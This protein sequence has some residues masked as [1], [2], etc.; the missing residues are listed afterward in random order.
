MRNPS[1]KQLEAFM[2][3]IETGTV[4]GAAEVIP[5]SQPAASKL[6]R[7][8]EAETRL[9]LFRRDGGR[10]VPTTA[11]LRLYDEVERLIGGINQLDRIVE[12]IRREG[13]RQ[14]SIGVFPALSGP[15]VHRVLDRFKEKY[16]D[17][18]IKIDVRGSQYLAEAIRLRRFDLAIVHRRTGNVSSWETT[19]LES[20]PMAC[21]LPKGHKLSEKTKIRPQD[22]SGEPFIAFGESSM[23][24][25]RVDAA[26][27]REGVRPNIVI[28]A[29]TAQNINELVAA[30]HGVTVASP[31]FTYMYSGRFDMREFLPKTRFELE[32]IRPIGSY[33]KAMSDAFVHAIRDELQAW[34][35]AHL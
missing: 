4:S 16:P 20:Q 5:I 26:F 35:K 17:T 30:G 31:L 21:I 28:E 34:T 8:L 3:V 9:E 6:I 12:T 25:L 33:N 7:N 24:R 14:I 11:G 10:L 1:L 18:R 2:A 19:P 22:L 13:D 27:D 32:V 15:F 23:T 29:S